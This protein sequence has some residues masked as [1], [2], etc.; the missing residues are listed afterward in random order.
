LTATATP[1][2]KDEIVERLQLKHCEIIEGELTRPNLA[3][4]VVETQDKSAQLLKWIK[5]FKGSLIVYAQSRLRVEELSRWLVVNNVSAKC[6]HAGL[7]VDEK[8]KSTDDWMNNRVQVMVATNAFGMGINKPDVQAVVHWEPP[9][10]PEAYF[11][12]AGRAGRDGKRAYAV[13]LY[14]HREVAD[15]QLQRDIRYPDKATIKQVYIAIMNHL[16]VAA[17]SGEGNSFDFDMASFSAAFKI[18]MLTATYAI[19]TLEQEEILWFNEVFFKPSTLVFNSNREQLE[20]FEKQFPSFE[21]LIKGLL[22]SYEGIFDYPAT[23]YETELARFIKK[24]YRR[25]EERIKAITTLWY[26]NLRCT[27]G[28]TST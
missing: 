15:M 6:Y 7:T 8:R 3:Y 28:Y 23:I 21:K 13:M 1:E 19:K 18:N 4:G 17:G 26:C 11:Q 24:K 5:G 10:N 12:E 14:N 20:D 25:G 16:Q 27:K 9:A 22:R 2:V